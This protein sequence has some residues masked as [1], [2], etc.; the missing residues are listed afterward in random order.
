MFRGNEFGFLLFFVNL[1]ADSFGFGFF[2]RFGGVLEF[3]KGFFMV[4]TVKIFVS[5]IRLRMLAIKFAFGRGMD[6]FLFLLG[7]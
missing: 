6:E 2:W 1:F 7:F 3:L 4:E 5:S